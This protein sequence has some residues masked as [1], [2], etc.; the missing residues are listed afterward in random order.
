LKNLPATTNISPT[1]RAIKFS[2]VDKTSK[3]PKEMKI[4]EHDVTHDET[5]PGFPVIFDGN[6]ECAN[7]EQVRLREPGVYD[8]WMRNDTNGSGEL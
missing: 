7:I 2:D 6:F 3:L 4:V 5:Q 8:I 1:H